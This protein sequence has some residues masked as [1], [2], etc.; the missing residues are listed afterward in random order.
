MTT[1]QKAAD[2][3]DLLVARGGTM[4]PQDMA[5]ELGLPRSTI[6]RLC[7]SMTDIG[8]LHRDGTGTY[9]R[10][11]RLIGWSL[12]SDASVDLAS[13]SQPLLRH[14]SETTGEATSLSI[15]RGLER[16]CIATEP[17]TYAL[18]PRQFA[19]MRRMLGFGASGK[20][21]LAHAGD[22]TIERAREALAARGR[23]VP[24]DDELDQIRRLG[25]ATSHDEQEVGLSGAAAPVFGPQGAVIAAV[26]LGGSSARLHPGAIQHLQ[27]VLEECAEGITALLQG[28]GG[29]WAS[30]ATAPSLRAGDPGSGPA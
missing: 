19:G 9:G 25:W 18:V 17:G 20:M 1:L 22:S 30:A 16:I 13:Q 15:S 6:H 7:G 14:L 11:P 27:G 26:A 3:I 5:R 8:L 28:R 29:S 2:L 10:G 24:S 12:A 4:R 21:L 23:P